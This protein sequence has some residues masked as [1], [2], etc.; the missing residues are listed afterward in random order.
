[1]QFSHLSFSRFAIVNQ[2]YF[3]GHF[4]LKILLD[5]PI[6]ILF[7]FIIIISEWFR[8]DCVF[9][10]QIIAANF[11]VY[12]ISNEATT[13]RLVLLAL[14]EMTLSLEPFVLKTTRDSSVELGVKPHRATQM[15]EEMLWN[16]NH[17][18]QAIEMNEKKGF[19]INKKKIETPMQLKRMPFL[20]EEHRLLC[21]KE[22]T[23]IRRMF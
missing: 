12:A 7:P 21:V 16:L 6:S 13:K 22:F 18:S 14:N 9:N 3:F 11:Y 8:W 2:I 4:K 23:F 20:L 1:M 17:K 10:L 15:H 5:S 19:C